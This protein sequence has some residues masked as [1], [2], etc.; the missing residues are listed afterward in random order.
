MAISIR[1]LF[2]WA[3]HCSDL[4]IIKCTG[5]QFNY[6]FSETARRISGVTEIAIPQRVI[7]KQTYC[8][9]A[10]HG[11]RNSA[12]HYF[13][14]SKWNTHAQIEYIKKRLL[15]DTGQQNC[16]SNGFSSSL[17][18]VYFGLGFCGE[19]IG[20]LIWKNKWLASKHYSTSTKW[21]LRYGPFLSRQI[22][23]CTLELDWQSDKACEVARQ[24]KRQMVR[25]L[26]RFIQ[27]NK[28][29]WPE[30]CNWQV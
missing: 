30:V 27:S 1:I 3:L 7:K 14:V 20:M 11:L 21:F 16:S 5:D 19:Q 4:G 8:W 25:F 22:S 9:A 12:K 10:T 23:K 26:K 6:F 29:A 15:F 24:L 18:R 28:F 2:N 13:L 17:I